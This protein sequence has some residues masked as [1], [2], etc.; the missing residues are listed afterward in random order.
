[1]R[2]VTYIRYIVL[3]ILIPVIAVIIG[4]TYISSQKRLSNTQNNIDLKQDAEKQDKY[5]I[6]LLKNKFEYLINEDLWWYGELSYYCFFNNDTINYEIYVKENDLKN[7]IEYYFIF[8]NSDDRVE[9]LCIY[10]EDNVPNNWFSGGRIFNYGEDYIFAVDFYINLGYIK[11]A[12]S[13]LKLNGLDKI[14]YPVYSP[15]TNEKQELINQAHNYILDYFKNDNIKNYYIRDFNFDDGGFH[16]LISTEEGFYEY[17]VTLS[18]GR[19]GISKPFYLSED[20]K[21]DEYITKFIK[22]AI[23]SY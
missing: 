12:S 4:A 11:L 3:H 18:E 16:L 7:I 1:M 13:E 17:T 2:K 10:E 14:S 5:N 6:E 23:V 22:Y 21:W 8:I 20:S 15:M 19:F 9:S